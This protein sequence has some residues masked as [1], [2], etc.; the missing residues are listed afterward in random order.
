MNSKNL[1]KRLAKLD[2]NLER[3]IFGW[4]VISTLTDFKWKFPTL[5]GVHRFLTAEEH[6]HNWRLAGYPS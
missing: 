3:D 5:R 4:V 2:Y 6:M 1:R